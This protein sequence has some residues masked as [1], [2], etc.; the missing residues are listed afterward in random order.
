MN[1]HGLILVQLGRLGPQSAKMLAERLDNTSM[2]I[3][4]HLQS[5]EKRELICDKKSRTKVGRPTRVIDLETI[6]ATP[7]LAIETI[8]PAWCVYAI[9]TAIGP[10]WWHIRRGYC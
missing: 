2:D 1:T 8:S 3:R 7:R 4:Q 6:S 5:L 10:N 9:M